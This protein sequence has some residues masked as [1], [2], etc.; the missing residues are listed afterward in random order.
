MSMNRRDFMASAGASVLLPA[1]LRA[2]AQPAAQ[3]ARAAKALVVSFSYYDVPGNILPNTLGDGRLIG[4]TMRRLRFGSVTTIQDGEAPDVLRQIG[5]YLRTLQRDDVAVMYFAGHGVQ[6][7]EENLL[8][9]P[10]G[11]SFLSL[12]SMIDAL[13]ARTDTVV[14][15]LDAC[16]NNPFQQVPAQ[17]QVSRSLA[18]NGIADPGFVTLALEDV[19]AGNLAAATPSRLRPFS[20]QGSGVKIVF[21]TDPNNVA[22][23]G[24]TPASVNSP[25]AQSLARRLLERRSLDDIVSLTTGDVIEATGGIQSPWSQ[26]SIDRPIF[27]AGLPRQRN[28]ARPPFQVPG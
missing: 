20:L 21:S 5:D 25:F 2:Q 13:R 12:R 16:R 11:Q 22:Y 14:F 27:L 3:A 18:G 1:A 19:A 15:F 26:G 7:G 10:G 4:D 17:A 8:V 6:I 23:D 24:A 9:L 28:P